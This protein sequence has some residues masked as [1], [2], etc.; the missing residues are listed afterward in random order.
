MSRSSRSSES[1]DEI[2]KRY[3]KES[4]DPEEEVQEEKRSRKRT[5][6][7]P[8]RSKRESSPRRPKRKSKHDYS[9]SRSRS[10]SGGPASEDSYNRHKETGNREAPDPSHCLGV[11]G[12]SSFTDEKDLMGV[13]SK[14]GEVTKVQ[15]IKDRDNGSSKGF[16]FV[17]FKTIEEAEK[18]RNETQGL[19][20]D[21]RQI[22]V[23]YSLTNK[24]HPPTPGK[25]L[26]R[27]SQQSFRRFGDYDRSYG[28]RRFSDYSSYNDRSYDRGYRQRESQMNYER[29]DYGRRD[30]SRRD[31]GRRDYGRRDY[32]RRPSYRFSYDDNYYDDFEEESYSR[33]PQ[34]Y[35]PYHS[36]RHY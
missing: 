35:A 13:F 29:R 15:L 12:L 14:Y 30:Y 31:F 2:P 22:R 8:Y 28:R 26:G 25:Y 5:S 3:R 4:S 7:K 6:S 27:R 34:R 21:R 9:R 32:E 20:M 18:A 19:E 17:Y 10:A 23:D 16:G 36:S 11:F 24:P 1:E 33:R